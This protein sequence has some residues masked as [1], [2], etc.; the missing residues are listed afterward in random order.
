MMRC[1][2]VRSNLVTLFSSNPALLFCIIDV[3]YK[4]QYLAFQPLLSL[5]APQEDIIK[6]SRK[7]RIFQISQSILILVLNFEYSFYKCNSG[8]DD[9]APPASPP[10][11]VLLSPSTK[12]TAPRLHEPRGGDL[13]AGSG[14]D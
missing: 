6:Y 9:L 14:V 11:S 5:K 8:R 4:Y 7:V 3:I 10:P 2:F 12:V 1:V 13:C